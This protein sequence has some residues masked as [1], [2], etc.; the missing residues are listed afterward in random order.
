MPWFRMARVWSFDRREL[1]SAPSY[2]ACLMKALS[3]GGLAKA[4]G[5]RPVLSP[6]A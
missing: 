4:T 3:G 6:E 1:E 5:N 2:Y